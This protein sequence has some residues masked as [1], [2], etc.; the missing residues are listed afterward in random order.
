MASTRAST[1]RNK[2]EPAYSSAKESKGASKR[3]GNTDELPKIATTTC[4]KAESTYASSRASTKTSKKRTANE[5][6]ERNTDSP[7]KSARRKRGANTMT[8]RS[9]DM[10]DLT[11]EDVDIAATKKR[12]PPKKKA[13]KGEERRARLFRKH[14]PKTYLERLARATSQRYGAELCMAELY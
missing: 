10:V 14:P 5:V 7:T 6:D 12:N 11:G 9:A 13:S 2:V 1:A 8:S 4:H 3:T